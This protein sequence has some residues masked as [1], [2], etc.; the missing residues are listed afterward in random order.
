VSVV[1]AGRTV[2][3]AGAGLPNAPAPEGGTAAHPTFCAAV[4]ATGAALAVEDATADPRAEHRPG[5][6]DRRGAM[7]VG[8]YLGVPLAVDGRVAGTLCVFD[9]RPRTWSAEDRTALADLAGAAA[10][11]LERRADRSTLRD[12]MEASLDASYLLASE[13]DAAG[14]VVDLV[15]ADC[16]ARAAAQ[17]GRARDAV[18]GRRWPDLSPA[19]GATFAACAAVAETGAPYEAELAVPDPGAGTRWLHVRAVRAG[20]GVAVTARDVSA[21]VAR[22]ADLRASEGWRERITANV[23]GMVYQFTLAPDGTTAFPYVSEG[24][25]QIYGV[26]PRAIERDGTLITRVVHP[27]DV[28]GFEASVAASAATLTPWAW[29]GRVVLASGDG[30]PEEKVL[31]GASRPERLPDGTIRWD[32]L[33][34]DVTDRARAE[35]ALRESEARLRLALDAANDGLWDWHVPS[36]ACYYSPR[37]FG[38][39]GYAAG[40]LPAHQRTFLD[41]LHPDDAPAV[42]AAVGAV[43]TAHRTGHFSGRLAGQAPAGRERGGGAGEPRRPEYA[44]EVRLRARDGSWRW[45]L[46][47]GD[48]VERD[49]GGAPVRLAGT[50][51]DLTERKELEARLVRQA[52][53]DGLTGL[54]NRDAFHARVEAALADAGDAPRGAPGRPAGA[55]RGGGTGRGHAVVL[56]LD[57]DDFKA[58]NDALGHAAGDALLVAAAA[59]LLDATRGSD[60]VA[61]L[62]GDEF[63]VLLHAVA[64]E[65]EAAVVAERITAALARPFAVAG[66]EVCTPASVGIAHARAGDT[67]DD[68][69][70]NADL[71]MYRAKA[72]GKGGVAAFAPAMHA[73]LLERVALA[74]DLRRA[75]EAAADAAAGA[76]D[77]AGT[78]AEAGGFHVA[79]QPIVDLATG[80]AGGAE[81]LFRWR[82]PTRGPVSPA[83]CIPLA[84][85]TGL[86]VPLGRWV[87]RAACRA[88]ARWGDPDAF[89]SVNVSARQLQRP[90]FAAEVSAALADAGLRADRLVLELTEGVLVADTEATLARLHALKALGVRLAVDD[91]GTGYS[92]L[93]YLHRF[94]LDVLKVDKTF[95]DRL[96]AGAPTPGAPTPAAPTPA[97]PTPTARGRVRPEPRSP[98]RSWGWAP[99]SGCA[100]WPRASRRRCS[101]RR[102]ARSAASGG[103]GYLFARPLAPAAAAARFAGGG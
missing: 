79:F 100:A 14:R 36:G 30:P 83:A 55:A 38:M 42:H 5:M 61:R 66:R 48:V 103:R 47:R 64:G 28:A 87:L 52:T 12:A 7:R 96:G 29:E 75:T 57:L 8:A 92:S 21:R 58:V 41:L 32:G 59:R 73:E 17:V 9:V 15:V 50:H 62:G 65:N 35:R 56:V 45:V 71:A 93:A 10:A 91:F 99:R 44:L 74:G 24:A 80:R 20:D 27:D 54:A 1:E 89:V 49:A 72:A 101:G 40:E 18:V 77:R 13:R 11:E 68:L 26:D 31:R 98:A 84:E 34:L 16:N 81:A 6:A 25:R 63:A 76:G 53:R 78:D 94:P 4:I 46:A 90:G 51:I 82:H 2:R 97:A 102:C 88:A 69:L 43:L 70:R 86:I 22:D 85:E 60:T 39:L 19:A 37:W 33:L 23:P 95:V 3:L 67:V